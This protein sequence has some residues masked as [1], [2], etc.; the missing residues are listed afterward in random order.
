MKKNWFKIIIAICTVVFV[1]TY[2]LGSQ[3][4]RYTHNPSGESYY[5]VFDTATGNLHVL[6]FKN[7]SGWITINLR[8][9]KADVKNS[10][11]LFE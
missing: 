7:T 11:Q 10:A 6:G 2:Y 9:T 3:V 1:I 4:G 5:K 8:G